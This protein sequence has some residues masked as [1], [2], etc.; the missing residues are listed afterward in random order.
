M[1]IYFE[2][3]LNNELTPK[4]RIVTWVVTL[5][6]GMFLIVIDGIKWYRIILVIWSI[7]AL[8]SSLSSSSI[9]DKE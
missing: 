9:E 3:L 1:S 6:L 5:F 4:E 8:Y 7:L 2:R